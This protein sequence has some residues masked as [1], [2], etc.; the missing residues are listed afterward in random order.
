MHG[1]N[2]ILL[3]KQQTNFQKA[4]FIRLNICH[5]DT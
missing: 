5:I 4:I 1:T 2:M 3:M